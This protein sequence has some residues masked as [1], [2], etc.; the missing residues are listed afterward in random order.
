ML[1]IQWCANIWRGLV[2]LDL[3][4]VVIVGIV[5]CEMLLLC[6]AI[7]SL[8]RLLSPL[9]ACT[10]I[11]LQL[12]WIHSLRSCVAIVLLSQV[13]IFIGLLQ[14]LAT[15]T[16]ESGSDYWDW[17]SVLLTL[18]TMIYLITQLSDWVMMLQHHGIT[19]TGILFLILL[20]NVIFIDKVRLLIWLDISSALCT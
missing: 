8:L 12:R 4:R 7:L 10:D 14:L 1:I 9:R 15:S 6:G 5:S 17:S 11:L 2:V 3:I 19:F 18:I 13:Q 20:N 16:V